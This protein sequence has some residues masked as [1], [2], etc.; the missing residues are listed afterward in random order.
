[1]ATE[2]NEFYDRFSCYLY[3]NDTIKMATTATSNTDLV[4]ITVEVSSQGG[5]N[6]VELNNIPLSTTIGELKTQLK[7]RPNSRFGRVDQFENWDNRRPL[8][9]YF[10][11]NGENFTCV[12]QCTIVDGQPDFDDYDE[13][14]SNNKSQ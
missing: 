9:D 7:V 6:K 3:N 10:A 4:S 2:V 12:I 8:S 14:L 1:M 11:K 5:E 13:W